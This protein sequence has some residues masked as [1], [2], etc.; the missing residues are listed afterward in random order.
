MRT[1]AVVI[2]T[3]AVAVATLGA[4]GGA[5]AQD[6]NPTTP[7]AIPNPGTY[8]GSMEMQRQQDQQDQQ[9]R[10]RQSQSPSWGQSAGP[11]AYRSGPQRPGGRP[12]PSCYER[13][14]QIHS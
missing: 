3:I 11:P 5:S 2:C 7:G 1:R 12:P 14:A 8:Q 13:I 9:F 6:E 10:Q 4:F